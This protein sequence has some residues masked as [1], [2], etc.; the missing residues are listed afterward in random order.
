MSRNGLLYTCAL[1]ASSGKLSIHARSFVSFAEGHNYEMYYNSKLEKSHRGTINQSSNS[2]LSEHTKALVDMAENQKGSDEAQTM[3]DLGFDYHSHGYIA[4]HKI[5]LWRRFMHDDLEDNS[6]C[7]L[8]KIYPLTYCSAL[9]LN[10][11]FV[12][13]AL[14]SLTYKE[15]GRHNVL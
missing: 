15:S 14:F 6:V 7:K 10:Y 9:R 4:P 12:S 5:P 11:W 2:V 1:H 3:L 13:L 8:F